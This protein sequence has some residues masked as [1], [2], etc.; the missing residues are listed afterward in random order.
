MTAFAQD[1]TLIEG[2]EKIDV[3]GHLADARR[4][5]GRNSFSL[6]L[7]YLKLRKKRGKLRMY[8]YFLYDLY[9]PERWT[10]QEREEFASAH[11]HWPLVNACN[12]TQWWALT[13][14]KWLSSC[15][16][17]HNGIPTP[18]TIAVFDR[19]ARHY[20]ATPKLSDADTLKS[21][22]TAHAPYPI[23]VKPI[24]GLWSAGALRISAQTETHV[25]LDGHEP[26]TFE[27]MAK[28]TLGDMPYIFQ[29]CL[30]PHS[31]FDGITDAVP[32][33]RSLN[34][35]DDNKLSVPHCVLKLPRGTNI[36][37]N[38]WRPG[39]LLCHLDADTG[40]VLGMVSVVDGRRIELD[41]LPDST[42]A[43]IG[44][45]LPHWDALKKLNRDIALLHAG[46]NFGSTD[47]ALTDEGPVAVEVNN[48]CAFELVQMA[49]GKGFLD[50]RMVAFFRKHGAKI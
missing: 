13:E 5:S 50:D 37:D 14:D 9:Q 32:T 21:F 15:F 26:Q 30:T 35:I 20:G 44:E 38:F 19:T 8:E 40:L 1:V 43:F 48:G 46:N 10:E 16:L 7:D 18:Q 3:A 27:E 23:F 33:V 49:T 12:N 24:G 41:H 29:N 45:T 6:A 11:I 22:L 25:I 36:A 28:T 34:I 42:R 39:N 4:A 47:I 31:I 2:K 17:E